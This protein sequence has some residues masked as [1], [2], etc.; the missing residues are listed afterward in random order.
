MAPAVGPWQTEAMMRTLAALCLVLIS[1]AGPA[2]AQPGGEPALFDALARLQRDPAYAGRIVG[3]HIV[4]APGGGQAFLYE[5]RILAPSDRIVIVYLDP[6]SGAVVT[7]PDAW[8]R[9]R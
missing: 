7:D 4:R 3:T 6:A 1:L 5:V 2:L 9:N 8:F